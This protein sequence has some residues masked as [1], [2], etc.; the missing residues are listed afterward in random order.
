MS[1]RA[2]ARLEAMGFMQVYVY[3]GGKKDWLS[4]DLPV[5]GEKAE[6]RRS[7]NLARR[8]PPT[9]RPSNSLEDVRQRPDLEGWG[10]C[11]VT[12]TDGIVHGLLT[13]S[14][15]ADGAEN[16]RAEKTMQLGPTT[17]SPNRSIQSAMRLM[18]DAE[19]DFLLVT[20]EFGELLGILYREDAQAYVNSFVRGIT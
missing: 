3:V 15:I 17:I 2:A 6:E 18:D 4:G 20:T 7:G 1:S 9:C 10:V 16:A 12:D 19:S 8:D 14:D 5:E 11:V 13:L